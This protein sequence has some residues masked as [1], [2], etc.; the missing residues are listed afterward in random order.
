MPRDNFNQ[1]TKT[2][3]SLRA[4]DFCSN[5]RCLRLTAGPRSSV[6]RGLATGDAAHICAASPGGPRFDADQSEAERRSAAN[7]LWLCRECRDMVDKDDSGYSADELRGS[8]DGLVALNFSV[9]AKT[10]PGWLVK[11]WLLWKIAARF[12]HGSTPNSP[13]GFGCR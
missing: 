11:S 9:L 2:E 6:L 10:L 5:P 13:I 4:A 7:G 8:E 1:P 12:G 3:I